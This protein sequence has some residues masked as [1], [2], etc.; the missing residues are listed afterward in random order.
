LASD[1]NHCYGHNKIRNE[2]T[3]EGMETEQPKRLEKPF[4]FLL[5]SGLLFQINRLILHPLGMALEVVVKDDGEVSIGGIWDYRGDEEGVLFDELALLEGG[6]KLKRFMETAGEEKLKKRQE[7]LGFVIQDIS[8]VYKEKIIIQKKLQQSK[9]PS[10]KTPT[11]QPQTL[12]VISKPV[13]VKQ[14]L[15]VKERNEKLKKEKDSD[16]YLE[17]RQNK[18]SE[19]NSKSA[20]G[21]SEVISKVS[22]KLKEKDF[23]TSWGTCPPHEPIRE[24]LRTGGTITICSRCGATIK[25]ADLT[26]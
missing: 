17:E 10:I 3:G 25:D 24:P 11:P 12:P 7:I 16:G 4:Q 23:Q 8:K 20:E 21:N 15:S 6:V 18:Q 13:E 5:D 2:K 26:E 22:N 14:R 9:P 19:R 1:L